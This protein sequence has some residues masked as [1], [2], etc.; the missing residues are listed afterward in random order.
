M[1]P[2]VLYCDPKGLFRLSPLRSEAVTPVTLTQGIGALTRIRD[3]LHT[4]CEDLVEDEPASGHHLDRP[5]NHAALA[6]VPLPKVPLN[7]HFCKVIGLLSPAPALSTEF[8]PPSLPA[9]FGPGG[10]WGGGGG[11]G[12]CAA[13]VFLPWV[14]WWDSELRPRHY[15][16]AG[17]RDFPRKGRATGC[18]GIGSSLQVLKAQP[19]RASVPRRAS[20]H[21]QKHCSQLQI[22]RSQLHS[23]RA[24]C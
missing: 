11:G 12:A 13:A 1:D 4:A 8:P 23:Y 17:C 22:L 7:P 10:G 6:P 3:L 21:Q 20:G 5:R 19:T 15:A 14:G 16:P 24:A 9:A 2:Q 18:G